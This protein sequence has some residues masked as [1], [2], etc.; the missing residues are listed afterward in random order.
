[1]PGHCEFMFCQLE[2]NE[3]ESH[4]VLSDSL[5][6]HGLY[7]LWGS[8]GQNTGVSSLPFLQG[9]FP[10]QGSHCRQIL[11]QLS[12]KVIQIW[13]AEFIFATAHKLGL[14]M[15]M[16]HASEQCLLY[17][18]LYKNE[19]DENHS[20]RQRRNMCL[21]GWFVLYLPFSSQQRRSTYVPLRFPWT[22]T[23]MFIQVKWKWPL[24]NHP[25][26]I[27]TSISTILKLFQKFDSQFHFLTTSKER[28]FIKSNSFLSHL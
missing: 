4:S 20:S 22:S 1:M 21:K 13:G 18:W 17:P 14:S 8:L 7:S 27:L 9:I 19:R 15:E 23:S 11:Y 10:T 16:C 2:C 25:G 24:R 3:T 26:H 5:Q 12:E 28:D 6:H